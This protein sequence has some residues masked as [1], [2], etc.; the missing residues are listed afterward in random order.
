DP[1]PTDNTTF[2]L[3]IPGNTFTDSQG[4]TNA[5]IEL[6]YT[7]DEQSGITGVELSEGSPA[8]FNL[9]GLKVSS[10]SLPAGIYVIKGKKVIVK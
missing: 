6:L 2:R 1:A 5:R 8:I 3:T 9:Q 4:K 7:I 10:G